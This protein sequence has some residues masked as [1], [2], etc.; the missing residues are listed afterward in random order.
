MRSLDEDFAYEQLRQK[1]IDNMKT[2]E[3]YRLLEQQLAEREKQIV[4]LRECLSYFYSSWRNEHHVLS[5]DYV[6]AAEE[7][8][9]ATQDLSGLVLCDAEPAGFFEVNDF[10]NWEQDTRNIGTPLYKARKQP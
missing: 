1:R 4:E 5:T 7:A 9:D 10:G 3:E 6:L 2:N 8:L